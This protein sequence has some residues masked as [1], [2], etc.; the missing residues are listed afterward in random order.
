MEEHDF[1]RQKCWRSDVD[2]R[3]G[4][5]SIYT[6]GAIFILQIAFVTQLMF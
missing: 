3:D 6:K 2:K 5:N 1:L 4:K